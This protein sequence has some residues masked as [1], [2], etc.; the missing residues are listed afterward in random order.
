MAPSKAL[1]EESRAYLGVSHRDQTLFP[2]SQM[3]TLAPLRPNQHP[4]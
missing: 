1:F 2:R 3:M 4:K